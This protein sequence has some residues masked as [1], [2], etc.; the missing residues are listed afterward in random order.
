MRFTRPS[1]LGTG[2]CAQNNDSDDGENRQKDSGNHLGQPGES[3][4][5]TSEERG[6]APSSQRYSAVKATQ[7]SQRIEGNPLSGGHIVVAEGHVDSPVRGK[8]INETGEEG[9]QDL[10]RSAPF[11]PE[12]PAYQ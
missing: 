1:A 8:G 2:Y 5:N 7:Q 11:T 4:E 10:V 9:R 3:E 12:Q 6:F